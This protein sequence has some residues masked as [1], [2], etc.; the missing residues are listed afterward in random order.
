M[1]TRPSAHNPRS[2]T[3]TEISAIDGSVFRI[4][5]ALKAGRFNDARAIVD[6]IEQRAPRHRFHGFDSAYDLP[7]ELI[8]DADRRVLECLNRLEIVT[9]GHLRAT[10][11]TEILE[12]G[13]NRLTKA[14]IRRIRLQADRLIANFNRWMIRRAQCKRER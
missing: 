13:Q 6:A 5:E 3:L 1:R 2:K 11:T 7:L 10:N 8:T 14:S 12:T 4:R 9:T